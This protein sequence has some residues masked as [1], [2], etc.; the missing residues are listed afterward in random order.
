MVEATLLEA[1]VVCLF[2]IVVHVL[3]AEFLVVVRISLESV[4]SL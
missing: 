4:F 3:E 1:V 2:V